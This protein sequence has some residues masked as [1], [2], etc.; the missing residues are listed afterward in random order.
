M[1]SSSRCKSPKD[2]F[3][4]G[5]SNYYAIGMLV[6]KINSFRHFIGTKKIKECI[7][8]KISPKAVLMFKRH[9]GKHFNCEYNSENT[10]SPDNIC[11]GQP[12]IKLQTESGK[13][14]KHFC[15]QNA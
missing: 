13:I 12:R 11:P 8:L 7:F 1:P 15:F 3:Q 10:L 4:K 6:E 14:G 2:I 9:I 5:L